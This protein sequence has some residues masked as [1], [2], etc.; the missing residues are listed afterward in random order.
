MEKIGPP[1][2]ALIEEEEIYGIT[3]IVMITTSHISIHTYPLK[4]IAMIDIFSCKNIEVDLIKK[5]ISN[6][7]D[8]YA[9]DLHEYVRGKKFPEENLYTIDDL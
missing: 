2:I 6:S 8:P 5:T 9:M 7:F 1:Q 3:G 4:A